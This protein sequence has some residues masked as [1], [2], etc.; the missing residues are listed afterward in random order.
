MRRDSPG[1]YASGMNTHPARWFSS[2]VL[3]G[4]SLLLLSLSSAAVAAEYHWVNEPG[5]YAELRHGEKPVV[6]YMYEAIDTSSEEAR[7]KTYK[8]YLHVYSPD[9]QTLLTKGPGGLFPHHRGIYYGFN[10]VTYGDGLKCDTWHCT[11]KAHQLNKEIVS[12]TANEYGGKIEVLI[13]WHGQKGETFALERRTYDV[14]QGED[15]TIIDFTSELSTTSDKP[16]QLDGDPQHAGC[17]FRASQEVAEN[18]KQKT[19]YLRTDGKGKIG[20]TRNWDHQKPDSDKNAQS[21][22]LPWN[23]ISFEVGGNRYSVQRISHTN[24]PQP[25][26][27]SERDYGRFGSYFVAEVTKEKPLAVD[28]RY[29]VKPGELDLEE[30]EANAKAYRD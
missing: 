6:R 30:C 1:G 10:K 27:F 5:K 25:E 8:P 21:I 12:T 19:Y 14:M 28:Y 23:A 7:E 22:N 26:R 2:L 9:G 29:I 16:I 3:G 18:G 20:E 17:H 11:G 24:V 4:A 15:E 13:E